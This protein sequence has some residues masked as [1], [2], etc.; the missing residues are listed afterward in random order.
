MSRYRLIAVAFIAAITV[1]EHSPAM[2]WQTT[3][4]HYQRGTLAAPVF[5][6]SA[7]SDT[8]ILTLQHASGWKFG[9]LFLFADY[10]DDRHADDFNDDDIY[11]ELYINFSLKKLT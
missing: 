9:D 2:Q 10:L 11:S 3:E 5:A 4:L 1:T 7:R 6:G 8:D